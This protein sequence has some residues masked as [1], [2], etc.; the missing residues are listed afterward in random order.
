[1]FWL[2]LERDRV[3]VAIQVVGHFVASG[4]VV[5]VSRESHPRHRAKARRREPPQAVVVVR[6]G[7]RRAIAGLEHERRYVQMV[8]RGCRSEPRLAPPI[9]TTGALL[10]R[11][12]RC[13]DSRSNAID[14]HISI[15]MVSV[16]L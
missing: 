1:V 15:E 16:N 9:T 5:W 10:G 2:D 4:V 8:Q 14:I 12:E 3:G 7:A 11:R 6:P 13:E